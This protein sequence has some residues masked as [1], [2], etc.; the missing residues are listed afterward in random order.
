CAACPRVHRSEDGP[1]LVGRPHAKNPPLTQTAST[2]RE[3]V[4]PWFP[5]LDTVLASPALTTLMLEQP[6]RDL[7]ARLTAPLIDLR[8]LSARKL[9]TVPELACVDTLTTLEIAGGKALD[10]T[11]IAAYT[12]L[13]SLS[14]YGRTPLTSF[15][16]LTRSPTLRRLILE[17]CYFVDDIQALEQLTLDELRI[18]GRPESLDP[19]F[20]RTAR[21]LGVRRFSAPPQPAVGRPRG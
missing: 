19:H 16:E 20:L 9:A 12:R 11:G 8:L 14:L 13:A 6:P 1:T 18:V 4:G 7:A 21:K 10:L 3:Y 15:A 5:A 17:E 2:L